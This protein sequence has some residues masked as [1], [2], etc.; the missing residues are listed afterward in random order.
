MTGEF[1][2]AAGGFELLTEGQVHR[3]WLAAKLNFSMEAIAGKFDLQ[4]SE[5]WTSTPDAPPRL[6]K[7]GVGCTIKLDGEEMLVGY[8]DAV[9]VDYDHQ[10]HTLS[11]KGREKT[12]DVVDCAAVVSGPHELRGVTVLEIAQRLCQPYGVTVTASV[13]VGARFTRWAVQPGESA[14]EA[15]D[16]ALRARAML[17]VSDGKGRLVL[18]K[19]GGQG[20]AA[21]PLVLGGDRGNIRRARGEFDWSKRHDQ[22]VV[23]GQAEVMSLGISQRN[24]GST[25]PFRP[26]ADPGFSPITRED[27]RGAQAGQRRAVA[28]DAAVRRHRPL[29]MI[30]EASDGGSTPQ[31]RA[32]WEV[33]VRR[34]R[35]RRVTYTV[36]GWRGATGA[37]WRVNTLAEVRDS[38]LGIAE[39]MLITAITYS[40]GRDGS[41]TELELTS[42]DAFNRLFEVK[43]GDGLLAEGLSQRTLGSAGAFA[44][45]TNDPLAGRRGS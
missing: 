32:E 1:R 4:L 22:V 11:I 45:A 15:I 14:W 13:P 19:A 26:E 3:G 25:A 16:R 24:V 20:S 43:R 33:S 41:L 17:A 31:Q 27:G 10:A 7:P 8:I 21:G 9:S 18:T 39:E 35:S 37:L 36:P 28:R 30:A 44:P 34:A 12:G 29:V 2:T 38:Y 6:V 42:R 5:R 40:V 23:R